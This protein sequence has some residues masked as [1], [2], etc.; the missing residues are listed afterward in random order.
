M[1]NRV[2]FLVVASISFHLS[3]QTDIQGQLNLEGVS[4]EPKVQL[5]KL[6]VDHTDDFK[7]AK[8]VIWTSLKKDGSFSFDKKHLSDKGGVYRIYANSVEETL[9]DTIAS[10][11]TFMLSDCLGS[12]A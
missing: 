5:A 10:G 4:Y 8:S 12:F 9:R 7:Y 2:L 6:D 3:A 11:A 1:V